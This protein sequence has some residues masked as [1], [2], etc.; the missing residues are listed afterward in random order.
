MSR[1]P[2]DLAREVADLGRFELRH[3]TVVDQVILTAQVRGVPVEM[4]LDQD[5]Y[6][7]EPPVMALAKGWAWGR[8]IEGL[9]S[10]QHWNRTLGMGTLLRELE[11]QFSEDPPRRSRKEGGLL[12]RFRAWLARLW[13]ALG[14]LFQK[15][16]KTAD[17]DFA[18]VPEAIRERYQEIIGEKASRIERYKRAVTQLT[19]QWQRKTAGIEELGREIERRERA[20]QTTL[21]EANGI[22]D[23]LKAK[24]RE[25][26]EIKTDR[27]YRRCLRAYEEV[28]TELE[29]SR[30]RF[31]ELE[32]DAREH[33]EKIRDHEAQLEAL[34]EELE[35]LEAESAEVSAD[36]TTVELEKEIVDLRAGISRSESDKELRKLLRQFRKTRASVRI[37]QEI[38]DLDEDAQD[39]QYLDI[40]KKVSAAREFEQSLG[41]EET[42]APQRDRE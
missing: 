17:E 9:R 12:D 18:T 42:A 31:S 26:D 34:T 2:E 36:L 16:G 35:E 4:R 33:L 24:G 40:A 25:L 20:Q 37:T 19:R 23:E 6:P 21:D 10:L 1:L 41:L 11:Q 29:E 39:A 30:E 5:T 15:R 7:A 28:S 22:V 27:R 13:N 3:T 38:A 32:A 8:R 14:R